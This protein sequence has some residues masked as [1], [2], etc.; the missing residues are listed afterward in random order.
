MTRQPATTAVHGAPFQE[1]HGAV[2]VPIVHSTTYRFPVRE[3]G[4]PATHIYTRYGNPTTESV[5]ATLAHLEGA[6]GAL[7]FAS[8]M[9][10]IQ[11]AIEAL[12]RPAGTLVLPAGCYGG[13][14]AL[15]ENHWKSRGY[16][17]LFVDPV[18]PPAFPQDVAIALM[19]THT[20]P[21]L[22]PCDVAQWVA[23]AKDAG[24]ELIVDNTFA[25][26][27]LRQPLLDGASVV[28]HSATKSLN[29]HSDVTAGVVCFPERF[30]D[31][32]W[33]IRRDTGGILDP[34]ASSL[35]GRG[36]KT[37][38]VRFAAAQA[39]A[40]EVA[41]C[42]RDAG[43]T[44]HYPDEGTMVA[45]ELGSED[46]AR[47]FRE[48]LRLILP[49]A[50]LGGVETLVTLPSETSHAYMSEADR[51]AFGIQPGLV[52]LSIGIE[53]IEDILA[54]LGAALEASAL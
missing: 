29:G 37:L 46:R 4:S 16:Q 3:D 12:I 20:N 10:A 43:L 47:K 22:K 15:V 51:A 48:G 54:D 44:V 52:R 35:L 42:F 40:A 17:V 6:D 2:N 25:T 32:L 14:S 19:E 21:L 39:N 36:L 7:L 13:T 33:L 53:A 11:A 27:L 9:A 50:S 18:S 8:G 26:P 28:V 30:R 23:R 1:G 5:E 41:A 45:V 38:G 34:A 24:V 49:A 31:R